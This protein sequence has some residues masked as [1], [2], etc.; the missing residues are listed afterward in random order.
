MLFWKKALSVTL[1]LAVLLSVMVVGAGAAFVDQ[2]QITHSDAV[3]R[4]VEKNIINGYSDGTYRPRNNITRAEACKMIYLTLNGGAEGNLTTPVT[5]TFRDVRNDRNSSWA[6]NYIEVC[7]SLGIV[8]GTTGGRFEPSANVTGTQLAKMLLT[9]MGYDA[10]KYGFI[11]SNWDTNVNRYGTQL[12]LFDSLY[13]ID[14]DAALSR[15]DAAQM[16]VNAMDADAD[17][18]G[19]GVDAIDSPT[20]SSS[21]EKIYAEVLQQHQTAVDQNNF[22]HDNQLGYVRCGS[23]FTSRNDTFYYAF[24]DI[25]GN[26]IDE[27]LIGKK[28]SNSAIQIVDI[29]CYDGVQPVH[30]FPPSNLFGLQENQSTV[31]ADGSI[32]TCL[33]QNDGG[34]LYVKSKISANGYTPQEL[35]NVASIWSPSPLLE[36]DAAWSYYVNVSYSYSTIENEAYYSYE[37]SNQKITQTAFYQWVNGDNNI[38]GAQMTFS[39]IKF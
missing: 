12:G 38:H 11:G 17:L 18:Y 31:Y 19:M 1:C 7:A 13:G 29:F 3:N 37:P 34:T 10:A 24:K 36:L 16:L 9:A 8:S 21:P 4:C 33:A 30:L 35:S 27:L 25:D 32:V 14:K 15:D 23:T 28:S 22:S 26:G 2:N 5:P 39:W 20:F 6:E